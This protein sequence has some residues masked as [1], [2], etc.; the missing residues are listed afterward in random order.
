MAVMLQ[1]KTSPRIVAFVQS[2]RGKV[3]TRLI[4]LTGQRFGLWTV[5]RRE[6]GLNSTRQGNGPDRLTGT[7]GLN[8]E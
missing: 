8:G 7:G 1:L 2:D 6:G 4:D 5:L 3:M